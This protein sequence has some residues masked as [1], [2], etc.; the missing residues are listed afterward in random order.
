M[1]EKYDLIFSLGA[2]P[3]TAEILKDMELQYFDFPFDRVLGSDFFTRMNLFLKGLSPFVEQKNLKLEKDTP[4]EGMFQYK[5]LETGL[6]YNNDIANFNLPIENNYPSL[7]LRYDKYIKALRLCVN[8]AKKILIVYI[9]NPIMKE[10]DETTTDL[11]AQAIEKL[12][13][14]YPNKEFKIIYVKNEEDENA[15]MKIIQMDKAAE[16]IVFNFY[17]KFAEM[18][19][20]FID[21]EALKLILTD[22]EL[23]KNWN[24]RKIFF[25]Q[26][27]LK[28]I[29]ELTSG[30]K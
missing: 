14:V 15:D 27:I 26:R 11:I 22:I 8:Q 21:I 29:N 9:E 5:D 4:S 28:K 12:K 30:I 16:K 3:I 7:K 20:Y 25:L 23:K 17:R 13:I 6:I 1:V 2:A 10:D 18:S 19:S 24:Q